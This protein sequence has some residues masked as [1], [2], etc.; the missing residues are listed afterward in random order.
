MTQSRKHS[1]YEAVANVAIG[2]LVA[3]LAQAVIFPL[4]GFN[5][6]TREH[7]AIAGLFTIVSLVRSYFLRR[8]FNKLRS[9]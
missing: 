8:L 5:A 7:M 9:I 1:A 3:I 2:Y 4:F 6:S